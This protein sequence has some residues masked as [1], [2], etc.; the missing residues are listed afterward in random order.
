MPLRKGTTPGSTVRNVLG[1]FLPADAPGG[2][3]KKYR[4]FRMFR[5]D[6]SISV[7]FTDLKITTPTFQITEPNF[8]RTKSLLFLSLSY[9]I[10]SMIRGILVKS[11]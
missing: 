1:L 8:K 7:M 10:S 9:N 6:V 11:P 5:L 4:M 3:K 2:V